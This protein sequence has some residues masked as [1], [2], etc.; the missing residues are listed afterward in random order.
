[1]SPDLMPAEVGGNSDGWSTAGGE[2]TLRARLA[3]RMASCPLSPCTGPNIQSTLTVRFHTR[4]GFSTPTS[5]ATP[6]SP[7]LNYNTVIVIIM[8]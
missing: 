6:G 4:L 3:V 2:E 5:M 8:T 7:G 1:M